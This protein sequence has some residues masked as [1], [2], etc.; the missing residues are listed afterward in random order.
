MLF[1]TQIFCIYVS[2]VIFCYWMTN[3]KK[4]RNII[5]LLSSFIFYAFWN[6][7]YTL[8]L[9]FSITSNYYLG[10]YLSKNKNKN[11]LIFGCFFNLTILGFFKYVNFGIDNI[12]QIFHYNGFLFS[13]DQLSIILPIGLSFY[14][15]Q[16]ISYVIDMYHKRYQPFNSKLNFGIYISFFPQLIAG[17]I[18]RGDYFQRQLYRIINFNWKLISTGITFFIIGIFKKVVLAD[19]AS[20]FANA[21]FNINNEFNS[22]LTLVGIFA[23]AFQIY[24]DFSGYTDMARGIAYCFGIKLPIN[25]LNP[26]NAIGFRDFWRRWHITLSNWLRDY[27][28]IPLGGSRV[29]EYKIYRNLLITMFLG[30]LWHGAGWNFIVWGLIHG[31]FLSLESYFFKDRIKK[32]ESPLTKFFITFL[33]FL[34]ICFA[35]IFFR[36][37]NFSTAIIIIQNVFL[38]PVDISYF[39][40]VSFFRYQN[41]LIGF[42]L[43]LSILGI[44]YF[45]A[46]DKTLK[47]YNNV[48]SIFILLV[49][50]FLIIISSR[51]S[52]EF[53]Y[54]QF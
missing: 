14:T 51:G 49:F 26:Y 42:I 47:S 31:I 27:L 53:I 17:P 48:F 37:E 13:M 52:S 33:T 40:Q 29:I 50:V 23:F 11:I 16:S 39:H 10:N 54:F 7:P 32:I 36:A 18:V 19:Q 6:V 44:S 24:F 38:F 25:F 15:F 28:F 34:C 2:F 20:V 46:F 1:Q 22:F 3:K 21:A 43:P 9:V 41:W 5:L 35:W 45:K 12:N 8:I 30:G 4:N